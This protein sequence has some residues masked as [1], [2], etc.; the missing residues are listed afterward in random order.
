MGLAGTAAQ[1]LLAKPSTAKVV[2]KAAT[3]LNAVNRKVAA[4][5]DNE[6]VADDAQQEVLRDPP[7]KQKKKKGGV[8]LTMARGM[9]ALTGV[10]QA[11]SSATIAKMPFPGM[12]ALRIG[13]GAIGRKHAHNHPPNLVAPAPPK[14]MGSIGPLI[15]IP[16]LSGA[17]KVIIEGSKAAMCGDMGLGV[18]C[19]GFFPFFEVNLGSASVWTEGARAARAWCDFT[20]H[21]VF[22]NPGPLDPPL[23]PQ[24]GIPLKGASNVT[25]GGMPFPSLVNKA[26]GAAFRAV[27]K[28]IAALTKGASKIARKSRKLVG[29]ANSVGNSKTM[30]KLG[31]LKGR[32]R[33][34]LQKLS[35]RNATAERALRELLGSNASMKG[36]VAY[37]EAVIKDL[38]MIARTDIGRE[39]FEDIAK[40]GKP[41]RIHSPKANRSASKAHV[42]ELASAEADSWADAL[43]KTEHPPPRTVDQ[44]GDGIVA[45][46]WHFNQFQE[47]QQVNFTD[48]AKGSGSTVVYDP[49]DWPRPRATEIQ[50][51]GTPSDVALFHELNHSKNMAQG[52]A[53]PHV[54]SEIDLW[55]QE[56][57]DFEEFNTVKAEQKYRD[58]RNAL[59][60]TD[61]IPQRFTYEFLP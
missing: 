18:W 28:G 3:K 38:R 15:K 16:Y 55:R 6:R 37:K 13:D 53:Q 8:L 58:Q 7:A 2:A 33:D 51:T 44:V 54:T 14:P 31:A 9:A 5:D 50:G 20:K 1:R 48:R 57:K 59:D 47:G 60:D 61:E 45:E 30:G 36:S 11:I 42:N 35:P 23:G 43:R 27:F 24:G 10:E 46:D 34:V 26:I 40:A 4:N 22:T 19:G 21:C 32:V 49:D 17:D 56:W 12:P 39:L 29:I 25:I 41:I 52:N